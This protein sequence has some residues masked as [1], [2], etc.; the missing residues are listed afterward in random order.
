[1]G[2]PKWASRT[3]SI[4]RLLQLAFLIATVGVLWLVSPGAASAHDGGHHRGDGDHPPHSGRLPGQPDLKKIG[5]TT[6][7]FLPSREEYKIEAPGRPDAFAH[8]DP[9]PAPPT[10]IDG[11]A[12]IGGWVNLPSAE[13]EPVCRSEGPRIA[14]VY[15]HRVADTTPTPAATIR[16]IARR[17]NWKFNAQASLSSGG[18]RPLKLMVDCSSGTM[19]VHNV[20]TAN[21]SFATIDAAMG[22]QLGALDDT[23]AVKYL[24]FDHEAVSGVGGL[25]SIATDN[26][27]G[28]QNSNAYFSSTSLV[29]WGGWETHVPVHELL[30]GLG[31]SQGL[32]S[33]SAPYSSPGYHCSDGYD[34]LCYDDLSG[35][36]YSETRCPESLG[37]NTPENVPIDCGTDTY[38]DAA[39]TPASWLDEYWNVAGYEN[40]FLAGPP[41]ATTEG[42]E[43]SATGA[44]VYGEV[45]T[46]GYATTYQFEYG[47]TSSY[48]SKV[49]VSPET[50]SA[51]TIEVD[52]P[53]QA[54]AGLES[55]TPATT[56]HYRLVASN[57]AGTATGADKTFTTEKVP[58][59]ATTEAATSIKGTEATLNAKV[60]PRGS[61]TTYQ[62]EYGK[63]GAYGSKAPASPASAGSGASDV[64]VSKAISGLTE[65]TT[66]Y[67]RV[68]A[69]SEE[70]TTN[71]A[72]KTF[73]TLE[74]PKVTIETPTALKPTE[75]TLN[76]KVNPKGSA[77]TYRFEIFQVGSAWATDMPWDGASAGSGT[78]D[79]DIVEALSGLKEEA[80]YKV[81]IVATSAGGSVESEELEFETPSGKATFELGIG[82]ESIYGTD[83]LALD[84]AGNLYAASYWENWVRKYSPTGELLSELEAP[85]PA[86]PA[87]D[88]EGNLYVLANGAVRKYDG[89][90]EYLGTVGG[91]FGTHGLAVDDEGYIYTV[92]RGTESTVL[93]FSPDG[94]ELLMQ[95]GTEWE[96]LEQNPLFNEA[97]AIAVDHQGNIYVSDNWSEPGVW[98]GTRIQ[99]FNPEGELVASLDEEFMGL[100]NAATGFAIDVEGNLWLNVGGTIY[101]YGRGIWEGAPFSDWPLYYLGGGG[102]VGESAGVAVGPDGD[103][104]SAGGV[105][106]YAIAAWHDDLLSMK[107]GAETQQPTK[108]GAN[109]ATGSA[110]INPKGLATTYQFE[111]G[112]T[113]TYGSKAPA[114]PT[115]AGSGWGHTKVSANLSGLAEDTPYHY[116]VVATNSE[117]TTYGPDRVFRTRKLPKVTT[118]GATK[119]N[120][121]TAGGKT[122]FTADLSGTVGT[123]GLSTEYGW[124]YGK[125]TSYGQVAPTKLGTIAS[126]KGTE[127]VSE[128]IVALTPSTTY[129]YRFFAQNEAGKVH[130]ED[131]TF[132]TPAS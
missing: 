127:T 48:G 82:E 35:A 111:Y 18:A 10:G 83:G 128:S 110:S 98:G 60:N 52:L 119:F 3:P 16:S 1:L 34:V 86:S 120:K 31:A 54:F 84:P 75:A 45:L 113:S 118:G 102:Q 24:V 132:T 95:F 69:T 14:L 109:E 33:P 105:G 103:V 114:S 58:P 56:Y 55:L 96:W 66:Y 12:A 71:G 15:T 62:F 99:K 116:R 123:E 85:G 101:K 36:G 8:V 38:F 74:R 26:F 126:G 106:G 65:G 100:G 93:K 90:G 53:L 88:S 125:T 39:P 117:G 46:G 91:A 112:K 29:Y 50:L 79:V 63:T 19:N 7:R 67:Y 64:E 61:A 97:S 47:T 43:V 20:A 81:K 80:Q 76:A 108:R 51:N 32:A 72:Q 25:S 22:T 23:G 129:H 68:V 104:Y 57:V 13:L 42:V 11:P 6:Y 130:G 4:N 70:G 37:Y 21:N 122:Y 44:N 59:K 49:P 41:K 115:S 131:K 2:Q 40:P 30:H 27:K 89:A 121:Y 124:E 92:S 28:W 107:P 5:K 78:S 77:T 73:T 87:T 94:K 9:A 17:M